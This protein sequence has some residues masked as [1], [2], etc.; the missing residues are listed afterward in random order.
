MMNKILMDGD[1]LLLESS[2]NIEVKGKAAIWINNLDNYEIN[3]TMQDNSEVEIY[4]FTLQEGTKEVNIR[5]NN[6]TKVTFVHTLK[7]KEEYSFKYRTEMVGDNNINNINIS[8]VS[9]GFVKLDVD[10][11][12]KPNT[13]NNI[14]NENIK[15][16]T[17][18]GKC[19]VAPKLHV[20]AKEVLAN[21]NTAIS[22]IQTTDLFY[23]KTKGIK[24][25]NAIKLLEDGYVYGYLKAF[26]LEFYNLIKE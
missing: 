25:E 22:N 12:A 17:I 2:S 23:L 11:V 6:N 16:L 19:F 15:I 1:K 18:G 10:G 4:D 9:S 5:Q 3:I 8:G 21:H 7:I 20:S 13:K 24:E 26:S 14:L